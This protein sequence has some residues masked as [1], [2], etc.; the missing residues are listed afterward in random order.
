LQLIIQGKTLPAQVPPPPA[1]DSGSV[2]QVL[3]PE[4]S[5]QPG[6]NPGERPSPA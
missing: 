2:Q 6:L 4:P 5:R 3:R 1:D